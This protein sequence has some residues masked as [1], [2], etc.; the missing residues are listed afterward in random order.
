M[1][2]TVLESLHNKVA[3]IPI[4]IAKFFKTAFFI[5]HLR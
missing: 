2:T 3:G 4:N 5:E 1:K